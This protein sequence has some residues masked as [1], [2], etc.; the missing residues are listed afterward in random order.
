MSSFGRSISIQFIGVFVHVA[1]ILEMDVCKHSIDD[2]PPSLVIEGHDSS[3][4]GQ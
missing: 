3:C 1:G 4:S 2:N